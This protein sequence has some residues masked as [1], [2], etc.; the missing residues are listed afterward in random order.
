M[1]YRSPLPGVLLGLFLPVL[2]ALLL[3]LWLLPD[4]SFAQYP[5]LLASSPRVASKVLSLAVL[6]NMLAMMYFNRRKKAHLVQGL[7]VINV[8]W[9]V[10]FVLQRFVWS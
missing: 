1:A 2:L 9:I 4:V 6:P 5:K 8:L 7:M 10:L 3:K